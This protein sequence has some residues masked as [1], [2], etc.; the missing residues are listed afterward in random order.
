[1]SNSVALFSVL[2]IGTVGFG[3]I[4]MVLD[5]VKFRK[6]PPV[7]RSAELEFCEKYPTDGGE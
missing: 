3:L 1:M 5:V 7:D 6:S 4:R 2:M